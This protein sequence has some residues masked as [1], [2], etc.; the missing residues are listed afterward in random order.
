M[1]TL[2]NALTK[3]PRSD[4]SA[5]SGHP[6]QLQHTRLVALPLIQLG[7]LAWREQGG[8]RAGFHPTQPYADLLSGGRGRA[9]P[10]PADTALFLLATVA[11]LHILSIPHLLT[12]FSGA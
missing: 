2:N 4:L 3:F 5:P 1:A 8:P 11:T 6:G 7:H 10:P 9:P 12:L